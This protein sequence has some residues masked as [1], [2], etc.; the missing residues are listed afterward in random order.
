MNDKIKVG[1][2]FGHLRVIEIVTNTE[3]RSSYLCQCVCID[4][5]GFRVTTMRY[6]IRYV[7]GIFSNL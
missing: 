2:I 1:D 6:G 4:K 7:I 5:K 3:K